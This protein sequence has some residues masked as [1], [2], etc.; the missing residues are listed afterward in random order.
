M[1]TKI[2]KFRQPMRKKALKDLRINTEMPLGPVDFLGS[3]PSIILIISSGL[4]GD[5]KKLYL[6]GLII[7]FPL[8]DF[9]YKYEL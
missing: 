9:L 2:N 5:R 3:R 1:I 4:V 6:S 7:N 8:D